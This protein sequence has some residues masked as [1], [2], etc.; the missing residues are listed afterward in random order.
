MWNI[1]SEYDEK[2]LKLSNLTEEN[3]VLDFKMS[4]DV[5]DKIPCCKKLIFWK[6]IDV[7]P[8]VEQGSRLDQIA[9]SSQTFNDT[10]FSASF[11]PIKNNK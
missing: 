8:D 7:A 1:W 4:I 2:K 11:L 3:S 10:N 5:F 9:D 6:L